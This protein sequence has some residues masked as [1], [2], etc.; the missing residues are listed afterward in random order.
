MWTKDNYP[1]A[2]NNLKKEVKEKAIEL[3][4]SL[5]REG[6]SPSKAIPIAISRAKKMMKT[7][8]R[9]TYHLV[10]YDGRWMLRASY[11]G[12]NIDKFETKKTAVDKAEELAS[13][14]NVH[15]VIHRRDGTIQKHIS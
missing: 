8:D 5:L 3:A 2:F 11:G 1:P 12:R 15:V 13:A 4:N 7:A 9:K 14:K 6:E 10:P